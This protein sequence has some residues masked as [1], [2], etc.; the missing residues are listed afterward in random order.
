MSDN[1]EQQLAQLPQLLGAHVVLSSLALG[2]AILISVP[3]GLWVAHRPRARWLSLA[4]AG[5]IQTI[6]GLA[7]LA[8]MVAA[9]KAFGFAPALAALILYGL[10]PILRN[11]AVGI[12]SVDPA[13]REAA[14][15][16]GMTRRQVM[17]AVEL[18]LALPTVVAGVRTAAVWI[19]GVATLS[20]PVGQ[21]S[22]G[23][24][25]FAGLQTRNFTAV[26]VGC[27]S[28]AGL[29][30]CIDALLSALRSGL[31]RR[32]R[33]RS[34]AATAGLVALVA[35]G[36]SAGSQSASRQPS[37]AHR[38]KSQP[39]FDAHPKGTA[40]AHE[41][42]GD[43]IVGSKTFTEQYILA[44]LVV[45]RLAEA[46]LSVSRRES[47][48]STVAFDALRNGDIDVYVDYTGTIWTNYMGRT[49]S[50]PSWQVAAATGQWLAQQHGIRQLGSLGFENAYALA[51][52]R[53]RATA[54]HVRTISDLKARAATLDI[55][56][57]Y[58]FFD[59]P[60]WERLRS[61]YSLR[62]AA[63]RSFDS[64]FMYGAVVGGEVDVITAFSSDGR[65][66]A[67]DL[68]VLEDPKHA[69]PPYDAVLLLGP[70]VANS[71]PVSE[72]LQPL[73]GSIDV[74]MMR[75]ANLRVDRPAEAETVQ[76]SAAWLDEALREPGR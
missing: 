32:S 68:T 35:L 29:A 25:I 36:A 46:G 63:R 57:D 28:A 37:A 62:F 22:L 16:V 54:L 30:L 43:V 12:S 55:G 53:D 52:R 71:P 47:L 9:M 44:E 1:L 38:A 61:T 48:G 67:L 75:E 59:R 15:G 34:A 65:I 60:E 13:V 33:G 74:Q 10:L 56:S 27:C 73:V 3:L 69:F 51:M 8:V 14:V 26:L 2:V 19:V 39:T 42:L 66:A 21:P 58:E 17:T 24:Y 11:T 70:R 50:G 6:P 64:T 4:I 18:P 49:T 76:Q 45:R 20:T 41:A 23:N 5:V 40:S 72:A 7:L 31:A